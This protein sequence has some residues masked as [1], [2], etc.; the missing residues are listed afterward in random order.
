MKICVCDDDKHTAEKIRGLIKEQTP[1]F[2]VGMFS[3]GEDVLSDGSF[4]IAF[5]D[6]QMS[7]ASGIDTAA[8]LKKRFPDIIIVFISSYSD[9]VTDAFSLEA[10]QYLLKPVDRDKFCEVFH[11]A[12]DSYKKA[13]YLHK[14]HSNK[15]ELYIPIRDIM[16]IET[17][18]RRLRIWT[19]QDKFEY[20]DK[21]K[22]EYDKLRPFDFVRAHQ[23]PQLD[24]NSVY[25][26][27]RSMYQYR[28]KLS[29]H[30]RR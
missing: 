6:I 19:N 2:Q 10:F 15:G 3:C 9:Y 27:G 24:E 30:C 18:G 29:K 13:H 11:K 21:I 26:E 1:E 16:Y 5:L 22:S 25:S 23:C 4:D 28:Q 8:E 12:L 17:Y 20:N 7:G 14:I